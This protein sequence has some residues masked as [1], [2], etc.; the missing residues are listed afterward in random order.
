MK[1]ED[2]Q[3]LAKFI[4]EKFGV[5][6][7]PGGPPQPQEQKFAPQEPS[8]EEEFHFRFELNP[9]KL[10]EQLERFVIKQEEA[11]KVLSIAVCDHYNHVKRCQHGKGC[12]HYQKQN[13]VLMGPTGVGKTYLVKVIADLVGVPFVKGDATKFSE[14][15][16]VGGD[17]EDLVRDLVR[18]A[19]G[20]MKLAQYGIIFLDE[21]DKIASP[22]QMIGRD[23]SGQGVQRGL[24]KLMEETEVPA[25]SQLD[26]ASQIQSMMEMQQGKAVK[27]TINTRHILFIVSGAF[28][29]MKEVVRLRIGK[30][31]IGFAAKASVQGKKVEFLKDAMSEDFINFGFEPEFIGRLPVRV[32]C[33]ELNEEDLYKILK[34]SEGSIVKQMEEAFEAY[35]IELIFSDEGMHEIS[36]KAYHEHTGARGLITICERTLRDFKFELP[37]SPIKRLVVSPSLV[38]S[39][40]QEL[41]KMLANPAYAEEAFWAEKLRQQKE[42]A[43]K[44][45]RRG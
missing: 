42:E 17:V 32:T 43:E 23:V 19:G 13:V 16:Y 26:V 20:N 22:A 41:K 25:K 15:G 14:T 45:P 38:Q 29:G 34:Y 5:N 7:F 9:K 31:Q 11:K 36:K 6:P 27:H 39:P 8:V 18:K 21:V 28:E 35:G 10:K 3:D 12:G 24:L 4:K 2:W 40:A 30:A 44:E 1:D 33:E 37:S